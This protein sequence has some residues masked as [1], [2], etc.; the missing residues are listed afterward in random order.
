MKRKLAAA[1]ALL[2]ALLVQL[3][4]VN[5]LALP[6]GG[7]P[8]LVLLCVI[9]IGM[10]G[11][12][13][14]GVIVGFGAGLALDL[15]P[16][17]SQLVGQYALVLCLVGYLSGRL[18]FTLRHSAALALIAAVVLAGLGEALSAV[19][20]L[21]LDTPEVTWT[22]MTQVLPPS[23]IYDAVLGPLILLCS[24]RLA[25]ALGMSFDP[26]DGSPALESG[27]SAAPVTVAGV[28]S[29]PG[30]AGMNAAGHLQRARL[31]RLNGGDSRAV[32]SG[33]WLV[34]DVGGDAPAMGAI[35]WLAGPARS[36]RARREQARLT[37]AV[38][39]ATPRKGAS[40]VGRRP[41]GLL[42]L[43]PVVPRKANGS[44]RLRPG[45]GV[46]G[47]ADARPAPSYQALSGRPV[48]L[49]LADEQRR[50]AKT[51]S[52]HA[53]GKGQVA[54]GAN[55]HSVDWHGLDRHGLN[56]PGVAK[57][58]FGSGSVAGTR[59]PGQAWSGGRPVGGKAHRIAFGTGGL[60]GA[61]RGCQA[62][63][64]GAP[65][66]AFGT[67]G[68][69]GAG[70]AAGRPG[71]R[72]AFG[73]GGLPGAG[74]AAGRPAPRIAFGARLPGQVR[75][76]HMAP[77]RGGLIGV[78]RRHGQ[79]HPRR[80]QAQAA[81]VRPRGGGAAGQG[82]AAQD[83][84]DEH[85]ARAARRAAEAE[86]SGGP[87]GGLADR[88]QPNGWF[89]MIPASRSRL[90]VL[91]L[92]VAALLLG[93]AARVWY[94][95]VKTGTSYVA[96]AT[97]ERLREVVEPSVRGPIVDDIGAPIVDS[98]SALV[99]SVSLPALWQQHDSGT[100]VLRRLAKLLHIKRHQMF[101]EVRLCTVGVKQPCWPGSPYQPIPVA[102]NVPAKIGLEVLENQR[103]FPGV[104]AAVQPVTRYHQPISTSLAQTLGYL[105]PITASELKKEGLPVTGFSSV[106]LVGQAGL[107]LQYDRALR[108]VP[109][110][111]R[112]AVNAQGQVTGTVSAVQPKP[113]DYLVT[114]INSQIQQDTE[115]ALTDAVLARPVRRQPGQQGRRCR[116]H[117]DDRAGA[118]AGQLSDLQPEHLV[119]R[120]HGNRVQAAVP[121][122]ERRADPEPGHPGPVRAGIDME[123]DVGG[124]RGRG[125]V[126]AAR[127]LPVPSGGQHRRPVVPERRQPVARPDEPLHRARCLLRHGVLQPRV[128]D[129]PEGPPAGQRRHLAARAG[130]GDA[131]D[132][133]CLGFRA[134]H[135]NR[136]AGREPGQRADQDVAVLAVE[137]Q[138]APRSELVQVRQAERHLRPADRVG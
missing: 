43:T 135:R 33:R 109:G 77:G 114:S 93:L 18:R 50:R 88:E 30:I 118:G 15:A 39:G 24:V 26:Q 56:G 46:A 127:H 65:R 83:R 74:R 132:G 94:L 38:T 138:R 129:L 85:Q 12:P 105:Q 23:V 32:A 134:A 116:R 22:T 128:P 42:P 49:G 82:P 87:V 98:K 71:P 102:E 75:A 119:G 20:T 10:T 122:G 53:R 70:R 4:I 37:A 61:G 41:P 96:Q 52:R 29:V 11:G 91:Y 120:H 7:T 113:G 16:P 8:D 67:G 101:R 89:P 115:R 35:G 84:P 47:S 60:P 125:R 130:A 59:R 126:P 34:G 25:V 17:A 110:Y 13:S 69:P 28:T 108:G 72:I 97:S 48:R 95:Q 111:T 27:G 106:D 31:Q 64:A 6:G 104:T 112:L 80:A 66:I 51:A 2:V 73:T 92:V 117:D 63:R 44:A 68:L 86:A 90:F 81:A 124:G 76:G 133:A 9:A 21:A 40:W 54:F 121:P 36:R 45:A 103:L 79:G 5:G 131:E 100:A 136:R 123:G 107:E 3:T 62:G 19:L 99:V 14:Y 55:G 78:R 58:A 1:L 137:G 57:I